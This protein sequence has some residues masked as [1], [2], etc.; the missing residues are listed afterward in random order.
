MNCRTESQSIFKAGLFANKQIMV[1]I[2]FEIALMIVLMYVPFF[3]GVFGTAPIGLTEW[4]FL[5]CLPLPILLIEEVR[6]YFVRR[7]AK[8]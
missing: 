6:K 1:G 2:Y 8:L 5:L 7:Y 3:Q 4:I